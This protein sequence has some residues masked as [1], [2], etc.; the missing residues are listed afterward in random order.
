MVTT[1]KSLIVLTPQKKPYNRTII[2][3]LGNIHGDFSMRRC[4]WR[5][6]KLTGWRRGAGG[7]VGERDLPGPGR[8]RERGWRGSW[9]RRRGHPE[10]GGARRRRL[11]CQPRTPS[12]A[13]RRTDSEKV[14]G[15]AGTC[16]CHTSTSTS[17][18]A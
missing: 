17:A 1:M 13:L 15:R 5:R 18:G 3:S 14:Q 12:R 7:R 8:P 9:R 2:Q 16:E 6:T 4:T 11:A 10:E